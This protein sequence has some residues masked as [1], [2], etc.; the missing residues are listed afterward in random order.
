MHYHKVGDLLY[1]NRIKDLKG[2]IFLTLPDQI[3]PRTFLT[4]NK[5]DK[6]KI[7]G[8]GEIIFY[9]F[10]ETLTRNYT[11]DLPGTLVPVINPQQLDYYS[12]PFEI[13]TACLMIPKAKHRKEIV[14]HHVKFSDYVLNDVALR[15]ILGQ[16]FKVW[17]KAGF[18]IKYIYILLSFTGLYLSLIYNAFLQTF[19]TQ[20]IKEKQLKTFTDLYENNIYTLLSDREVSYFKGINKNFELLH[21][22]TNYEE[23]NRMRSRLNT[24]YAYPTIDINWNSLFSYQQNII[25]NKRFIFSKDACIFHTNFLSFPLAENSIYRTPVQH[26]IMIA[27]DFGLIKRWFTINFPDQLAKDKVPLMVDSRDILPGERPLKLQDFEL[28]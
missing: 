10:L 5:N 22:I 18:F 28:I 14:K 1:P 3:I 7:Y 20:P 8:Y 6:L 12:Y 21:R 24:S 25:K 11:I 23:F 9:G 19:F 26:L 27:R 13:M 2:H 17:L 15:G 16:P 4:E